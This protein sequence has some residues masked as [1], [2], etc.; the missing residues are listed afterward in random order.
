MSEYT[1]HNSSQTIS[2]IDRRLKDKE[3]FYYTRFSHGELYQIRGCPSKDYE[4]NKKTSEE[5]KSAFKIDD[6]SYMRGIASIYPEEKDMTSSLF[7]DGDIEKD[8]TMA[9]LKLLDVPHDSVFYTPI[10]FHY[11]YAFNRR[12]FYDFMFRHVYSNDGNVLYIGGVSP[13]EVAN[14]LGMKALKDIHVPKRNANLKVDTIF[15]EVDNICASERKPELIIS[16]AGCLSNLIAYRMYMSKIPVPFID[17]GSV[18]TALVGRGG[19]S[20]IRDL[21]K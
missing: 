19:W 14:A 21:P 9:A 16:A 17:L 6:R 18:V 1:I 12:L 13:A 20:W 15:Q 11:T 8:K 5:L 4:Y 7:L 10:A 3:I 2:E